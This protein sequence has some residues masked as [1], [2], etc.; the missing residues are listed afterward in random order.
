METQHQYNES[1]I[2][3][4]EQAALALCGDSELDFEDLEQLY[5]ALEN[6]CKA[7]ILANLINKDVELVNLITN[8]F[9]KSNDY[10]LQVAQEEI[11]NPSIYAHTVPPTGMVFNSNT[12]TGIFYDTGNMVNSTDLSFVMTTAHE[13]VHVH[14]FELF[15]SNQLLSNYPTYTTLNSS[16]TNYKSN[17]TPANLITMINE[18][19][20]V[21]NDFLIMITDVVFKYATENNIEGATYQYCK[22]IVVGSHQNTATYLNLSQDDK[23]DYAGIATNE[24]LGLNNAKGSKC[25]E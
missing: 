15:S 22:K 19:H 20:S 9:F 23:D 14:L 3:F 5:L 16:M 17:P 21:Y 11:T 13:F 6:D 7:T 24:H 4:A 12:F 8:K 1:D 18:M 25:N 2:N 10:N